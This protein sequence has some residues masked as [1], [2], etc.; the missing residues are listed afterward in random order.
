MST[1]LAVSKEMIREA[2]Q[3]GKDDK[4]STFIKKNAEGNISQSAGNKIQ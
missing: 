3:N 1:A 4:K 2:N